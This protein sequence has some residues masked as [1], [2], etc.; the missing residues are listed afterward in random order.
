[1]NHLK[2]LYFILFYQNDFDI[3]DNDKNE[4]IKLSNKI[5]LFQEKVKN[6]LGLS[7]EWSNNLFELIGCINYH[8]NIM[9][10]KQNN[11]LK[12]SLESLN[13]FSNNFQERVFMPF[14]VCYYY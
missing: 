6:F 14:I 10:S 4:F 3:N 1:M 2:E 13:T 9:N 7:H 12:Q 5:Y 11:S 8:A